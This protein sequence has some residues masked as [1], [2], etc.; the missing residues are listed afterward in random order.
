[1]FGLT[2]LIVA[3]EEDSKGGAPEDDGVGLG[4]GEDMEED[5]EEEIC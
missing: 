5:I 1:M 2:L 4:G 3:E